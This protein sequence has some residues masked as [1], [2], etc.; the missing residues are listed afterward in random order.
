MEKKAYEIVNDIQKRH[1]WFAARRNILFSILEKKYEKYSEGSVLDIG[2]GSGGN[3]DLL[4]RFGVVTGV[5]M[6]KD[7]LG[8]CK[9]NNLMGNFYH[10]FL[11][12][13][14]P[15][16]IT[17]KKYNLIAMLDVLEHIE[18]DSGAL[19]TICR[20]NDKEGMLLIT[21]PAY[22]WLFS[23]ADEFAWHKRRYTKKQLC[24]KLEKSGYSIVYST[25]YN[26]LLFPLAFI[27]RMCSKRRGANIVKKELT[28]IPGINLILKT[29]F[30][31][32]RILIPMIKFP[33]GLSICVLA[34][35]TDKIY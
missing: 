28:I 3:F 27:S 29:V 26:T 7:A 8:Y 34:E 2:A 19:N 31:F 24:S 23:Q 30:S 1:W 6:D 21:V 33:F 10:G 14:L 15:V 18:D 22:Q 9:K 25:Y 13:G 35:K 5:E 4:S 20:L 17:R 32:E 16:E 11:P 12:D